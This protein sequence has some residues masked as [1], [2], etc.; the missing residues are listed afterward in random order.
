VS[1]FEKEW[2]MVLR[3]W[4]SRGPESPSES[5]GSV[6]DPFDAG[7]CADRDSSRGAREANAGDGQDRTVLRIATLRAIG[8]LSVVFFCAL[9]VLW[10]FVF[11]YSAL[12]AL[13]SLSFAGLLGAWLAALWGVRW[14]A[15][16]YL[17]RTTPS[18]EAATRLARYGFLLGVLDFVA[19]FL[20]ASR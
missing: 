17:E 20:I 12:Q 9:T 15:V 7:C 5:R 2:A 3:S 6:E 13:L 1:V 18:V 19:F 16:R 4:I 8:S 11:R 10:F 14:G